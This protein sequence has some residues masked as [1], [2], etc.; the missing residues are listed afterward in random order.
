[1]SRFNLRPYQ[2]ECLASIPERGAFLVQMATGLGKTV[3]FSRVPRRGRMLILSHREELVWQPKKYFSCSFGVEQAG[4][5]SDGEEVVS[6][7]V[8]SLTRRL[9]SF[10][11]DDFDVLITDEAHHASA[12]TYR[13]IYDHFKPRLHLGFTATPNRA[14]GLGLDSIFED[15]IF[16]R[17]LA[18]GI[19]NGWLSDI[20]CIRARVGF[21]LSRVALRLGDYAAGELEKAVNIESANKAI[22]DVYR[23]YAGKHT[24][25]FAAGVEHAR[26]LAKRIPGAVAVAGGEERENTVS[27][28]LNGS[29]PCLV[30]CMVFTEGTDLPNVDTVIIARPTQSAGLYMQMVGRGTRTCPGKDRLMLIDCVGISEAEG[31]CTAPT[32]IGL[33][34]DSLPEKKRNV[35]GELFSLPEQMRKAMDTPEAH[36]RNVEYVDLW[37]RK[38]KFSLHGVNWFKMP[39]GRLVLSTPK[40]T[41]PPPD[42]LG[43]MT[44]PSGEIVP[45]QR[46][47]DRVYTWLSKEHEDKRPLWDTKLAK[48]TWGG[49]QATDK[50]KNIIRRRY[51]DMDVENLTKFQASQLLTRFFNG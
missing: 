34:P 48:R 15:I 19:R 26:E 44:L 46:V 29:I 43:R 10:S 7:S 27:S 16:E 22:A 12:P 2:Q 25:I 33:D 50:Q 21:D 14:D 4:H 36:I 38:M 3:T 13:R 9:N 49:Y 23:Q 40:V 17:D 35:Q 18:W 1:M 51:P 39:D 37:A 6:A 28:F 8:Q 11:P 31:L 5:R 20:Y 45:A 41:L 30:N 47:F 32:L 42:H 24:L